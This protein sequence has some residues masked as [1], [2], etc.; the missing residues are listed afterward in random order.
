MHQF[1]NSQTLISENE[2]VGTVNPDD[3]AISASPHPETPEGLQAT[4]A[5]KMPP[6]DENEFSTDEGN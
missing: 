1:R 6:D 4:D 5:E 3:Q 2:P